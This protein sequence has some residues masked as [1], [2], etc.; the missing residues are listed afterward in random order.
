MAAAG[1]SYSL[2]G[3]AATITATSTAATRAA[4]VMATVPVFVNT[5][6]TPRDANVAGV[7][8]NS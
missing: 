7:M 1:G 6:A 4:A 3:A 5:G 2:T 8:V